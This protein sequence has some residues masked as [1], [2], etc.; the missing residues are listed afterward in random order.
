MARGKEQGR[1]VSDTGLEKYYR[2]KSEE[3]HKGGN[4]LETHRLFISIE[5]GVAGG[6][7]RESRS[8]LGKAAGPR[9]GPL[10]LLGGSP[11]RLLL[12]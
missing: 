8:S 12:S 6:G 7:G 1:R 10:N 5:E 3:V 4:P 11:T 9:M 2:D